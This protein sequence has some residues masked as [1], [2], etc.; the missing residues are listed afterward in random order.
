MLDPATCSDMP[1]LRAQIDA[2]DRELVHLL[3]LRAAHIDRAIELKQVNGWPAR[4]P[5]RVEEVVGKVRS[6]SVHCGLD[7]DLTER[8]WRSLIEW[9]IDREAR[10]ICLDE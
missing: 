4:I 8:I 7:P 6:E 3:R 9:S 5:A 10:V 1:E 2:L